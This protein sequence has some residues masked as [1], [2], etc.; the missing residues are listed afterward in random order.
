MQYMWIV[1]HGDK[2]S[3]SVASRVHPHCLLQALVPSVNFTNRSGFFVLLRR[4]ATPD[5]IIST[6]A[7]R[8]LV[9]FSTR[10]RE[11]VIQYFLV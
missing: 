9:Q 8:R 7:V 11:F 1:G 2:K 10:N 6:A 3:Y 4:V 5:G